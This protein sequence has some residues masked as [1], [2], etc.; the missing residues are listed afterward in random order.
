MLKLMVEPD[1]FGN[2]LGIEF[3]S[4]GFKEGSE[5]ALIPNMIYLSR[6]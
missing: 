3:W 5:L 1:V 2:D 6:V 4:V